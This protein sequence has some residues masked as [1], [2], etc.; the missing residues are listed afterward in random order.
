MDVEAVD[1]EVSSIA[2]AIGE[3]ARARML[4]CLSDGRARTSTELAVVADISP[5]TASAHL[6][7]LLVERLVKVIAQGKHRYYS[8]EG[9]DVAAALEALCVLAG[10]S[11]EAFVPNTPNPLRFARTCYDHI[12]GTLGVSLHDRF[13]ALGWLSATSATG[14]S[15]E[16][17]SKGAKA[18]AALGI[19]IEATRKLRRRFAY[20]CVDWSE[21]RPHVGGAVGAALLGVALRRKWVIQDLDS[22]ALSIT[23]V[24]RREMLA[25]FGIRT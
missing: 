22:R 17:P 20:A 5:S 13:R 2:A 24:G 16:I 12:A 11:R 9:A 1:S 19:D 23:K 10:G 14:N 15:Y 6:Q 8:L 3:P 21:R 25:R 18:F 7:R 4:Y